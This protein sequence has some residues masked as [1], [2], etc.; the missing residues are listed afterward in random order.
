[1][2][3]NSL[4]KPL[5]SVVLPTYK[6]GEKLRKAIE[7]VLNQTCKDLEII[8]MDDTPDD[9]IASIVFKIKDSRIKY[10]KNKE[11]LGFV[12]SLN[13]SISLSRG[14]YIARIDADDLWLDLKKLE[15]QIEFLEENPD[16]ILVGG[17]IIIVNEAGKELVRFLHPEKDKDIRDSILLVD[18]FTHSSVLIRKDALERVSGYD[19]SLDF[20]EDWDLWLKLGKIGKFYNFSEYFVRYLKTPESRSNRKK[21]IRIGNDLRRKYRKDYPN[22][23]RAIIYSYLYDFYYLF[24][25]RILYPISPKLR[26][27]VFRLSKNSESS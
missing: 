8:I 6:R 4:E 24:L 11:R 20:A 23:Y 13:K 2:P 16:Y 1:M 21:E 9:S 7:S 19:E 25:R 10:I 22:F 17:G 18:N 14:K 5:V 15:K 3:K 26:K 12:K 27:L